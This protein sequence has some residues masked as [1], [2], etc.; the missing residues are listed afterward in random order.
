MA[1]RL[2]CCGALFALLS[3]CGDTRTSSSLA[4]DRPDGGDPSAR[5][6]QAQWYYRSPEVDVDIELISIEDEGGCTTRAELRV[7]EA[8][9]GTT[10]YRMPETDCAALQLTA[11][12]DL[13][14]HGDPTT[15]DWAHEALDVDTGREQIRLGPW[16]DA[17]RALSYRFTLS[18]PECPDDDD[19][20]C[21]R[22]ERSAGGA[23]LALAFERRCD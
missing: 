14:L 18:A 19:C 11:D 5:R 9:A 3:S 8:L 10:R 20:E 4:I 2:A 13:V 21:P 6:A 17:E 23:L 16:L 7:D 12:G 22:L 1:L 15:H